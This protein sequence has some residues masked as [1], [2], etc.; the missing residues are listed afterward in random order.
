M[1]RRSPLSKVAALA[2]A[3]VLTGCLGRGEAAS[4]APSVHASVSLAR[5]G[6]LSGAAVSQ[7]V[8]NFTGGRVPLSSVDSLMVTVTRVDVLPDSVLAACR[9][10]VG[11]STHGFRPGPPGDL[12]GVPGMNGPRGPGACA[13][14]QAGHG[15]MGPP[16]G[17]GGPPDSVTPFPRPDDPRTHND[18]LLPPDSGWGSRPDHWYSLTVVGGGR[19]DLM[20][21]PTDTVPAG[22]YGAARLIVSDATIW[23]NTALTTKDSVTLQPNTGYA[24]ELP[25]RGGGSMGIMTNAGF[26]VPEGG[27]N[28][29]LIFDANQMLA[30]PIVTD[31][32]KVVLGPMLRPHRGR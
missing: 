2:A 16:P 17:P 12:G 20:H 19:I 27:G 9:P 6:V 7:L 11:D 21:L 5:A 22:A 28:V 24:V 8:S 18:S 13:A 32:G 1:S 23:L 31:S 26:T 10:P 14:W 3:V 25:H 29:V 15:M 30:S 4:P